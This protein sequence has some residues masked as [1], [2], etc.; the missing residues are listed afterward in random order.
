[1]RIAILVLVAS[2]LLVGRAKLAETS[3]ANH[4]S[5]KIL[6]VA[7]DFLTVWR[8]FATVATGFASLTEL[9]T[10]GD[11]RDASLP[12]RTLNPDRASCRDPVS[13][14]MYSLPCS[15]ELAG[16]MLHPRLDPKFQRRR[17]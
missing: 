1:M 4:L 6:A 11:P 8:E 12:R 10:Y 17:S 14:V 13:G 5:N 2:F 7:S 16:R 9:A 3:T 15:H